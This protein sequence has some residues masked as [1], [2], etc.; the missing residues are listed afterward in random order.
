[1]P[2]PLIVAGIAAGVSL[3]G[4]II[5]GA[6]QKSQADA[7]AAADEANARLLRQRALEVQQEGQRQSGR[8][9]M[10]GSQ[11]I[12]GQKV[13]FAANG[14]DSTSGTPLALMADSRMMSELDAITLRNNAAREARGLQTQAYGL[15]RQAKAAHRAGNWALGG[16]I[17]GGL[18]SSAGQAY[19]SGLFGKVA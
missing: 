10:A 3:L 1:M 18:A 16:S 5:G 4:N 11:A 14:V 12:S 2:F 9:R 7:Q 19:N 8:A 6:G 13:A 15:E 17:I